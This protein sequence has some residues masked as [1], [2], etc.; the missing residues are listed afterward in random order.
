MS[1]MAACGG[2]V[3][4]FPVPFG[5]CGASRVG[6]SFLRAVGLARAEDSGGHWWAAVNGNRSGIVAVRR[7][8]SGALGVMERIV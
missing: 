1:G 7:S 6:F 4:S 8:G 2:Q 3:T 5:F